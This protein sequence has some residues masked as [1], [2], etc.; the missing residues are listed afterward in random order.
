MYMLIVTLLLQLCLVKLVWFL[1]A[2]NRKSIVTS[3]YACTTTGVLKTLDSVYE[4]YENI[5]KKKKQF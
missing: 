4:I 3:E 2:V 1:L 5:T